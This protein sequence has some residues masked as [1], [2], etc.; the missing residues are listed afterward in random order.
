MNNDRALRPVT[1]GFSVRC[2]RAAATARLLAWKLV[3]EAA[4]AINLYWAIGLPP[5]REP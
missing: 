4:P 5:Y 1:T 3:L 2:Q